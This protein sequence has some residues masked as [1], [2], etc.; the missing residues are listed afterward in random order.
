MAAV[1]EQTCCDRRNEYVDKCA[2]PASVAPPE[3]E[4][5]AVE[6]APAETETQETKKEEPKVES[7]AGLASL[8]G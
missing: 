5:V 3:P 1:E 6:E 8:F 4:V 2:L 7:A